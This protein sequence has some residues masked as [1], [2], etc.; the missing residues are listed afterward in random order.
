M[1]S[2]YL[3]C[4]YRIILNSRMILKIHA[5]F[6]IWCSRLETHFFFHSHM[7]RRLSHISRQREYELFWHA[8]WPEVIRIMYC[9]IQEEE[10]KYIKSS[11]IIVLESIQNIQN[12]N[13]KH[14][15]RHITWSLLHYE[16]FGARSRLQVAILPQWARFE[17]TDRKSWVH[18]V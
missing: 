18:K 10:D 13:L 16:Y 3:I 6:A 5:K 7:P 8:T 11:E 15:H 14:T 1:V 12:K 4:S 2:K 17:S 9:N